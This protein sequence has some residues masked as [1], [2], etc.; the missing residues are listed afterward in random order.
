VCESRGEEKEE[1]KKKKKKD[2]RCAV[3]S[4]GRELPATLK[5]VI[6]GG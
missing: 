3:N 5:K 4:N 2:F 6:I 1:M